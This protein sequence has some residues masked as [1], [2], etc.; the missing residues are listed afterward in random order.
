MPFFGTVPN[1]CI[2]QFLRVIPF[3]AWGEVY[4]GCSGTLKIEEAIRLRHPTIPIHANDVS[5][6]SCPLGWYYT[7]NPQPIGFHSRLDFI[8][9]HIADQP[10]EYTVAAVLVAQELARYHRDNNYCKAH[11]K[12]LQET[13]AEHVQKGVDKLREKKAKLNLTSYFAG[14][15]RDHMETAIANGNGIASFPPFFGTSDYASQFKFINQNITWA[16]PSFRDY[17]AEHFRIALERCIDSGVNYMLLSDQLFDDIRPTLEFV[18]GRKVPHYMY[19][20]HT[21]S[22]LRHLFSKP[23]PFLYTPV[24]PSKLTRDSTVEVI[25]AENKHLNFIKD[26]YLAKG[27]IHS[28]GLTNYLIF[29]DGML[30]GG[31]IYA[32]QKYGVKTESGESYEM[33]QCLYLLSDVTLSNENKLSKLVAMLAISRT[34]VQPLQHKLLSPIQYVTTTARSKNPVS[35]KYRGIYELNSRRPSE[36]VIDNGKLI[37]QYGAKVQDQTPTQLYQ[38]WFDRYSGLGKA[39]NNGQSRRNRRPKTPN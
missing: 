28:T 12:H 29:I 2:E 3:D 22:S 5:L 32:L 20:N 11:F 15:W 25:K 33:S 38:A 1:T 39:G 10:Y 24:V 23:E 7:D 27:I 4:V 37:L 16:E 34:L 21:R 19:S 35:M 18:Q 6:F 17:K 9:A 26:V 13:F 30:A 31:I 36:D 8:N 14:D